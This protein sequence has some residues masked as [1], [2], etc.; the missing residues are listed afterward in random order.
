MSVSTEFSAM[1]L[2]EQIAS[3]L[4]APTPS[5]EEIMDLVLRSPLVRQSVR[6]WY[7]AGL[8][9][10]E[11]G[12]QRMPFADYHVDAAILREMEGGS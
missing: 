12:E 5:A 11:Q 3:A 2:Q 7:L 10:Q 8:A 4:E 1:R 6:R 9:E